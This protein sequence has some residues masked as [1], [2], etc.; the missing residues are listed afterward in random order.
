[1]R[2][3]CLVALLAGCESY[4]AAELDRIHE[5]VARDAVAQYQIA[6]RG[7]DA[8]Q[9]C[10]HAGMVAAAYLQAQDEPH[11]REWLAVER[12]ECDAAGVPR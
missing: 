4:A 8:M 9:A 5:Q 2:L 10:V 3:V 6:K 7:G 11:Y 12:R 1:M